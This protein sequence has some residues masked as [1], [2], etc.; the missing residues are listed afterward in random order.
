M[1]T[2]GY[3]VGHAQWFRCAGGR[4]LLYALRARARSEG[5]RE[6]ARP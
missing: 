3:L 6:E 4:G 1:A 2:D 5:V